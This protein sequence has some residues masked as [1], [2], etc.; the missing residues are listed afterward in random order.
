MADRSIKHLVGILYDILVKVDRFIFPANFVILG[1]EIDAEI[2]IVFGRPFVAKRRVLVDVKSGDLK[3]RVNE[4]EVTFNV[5]YE[6]VV[7]VLSSFRGY[8]KIPLTL[9][10][11]LKNRENP[12]AKPPTED[13]PSLELKTLPLI[14]DMLSFGQITPY[15]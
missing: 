3:F 7:D 1:Y 11:D 15:R 5:C 9:E 14:S 10:I 13:P 12:P 8:S 2:P 4:D 6:E